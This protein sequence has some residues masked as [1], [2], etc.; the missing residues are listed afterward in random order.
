MIGLGHLRMYARFALGLRGFLAEPTT[1]EVARSLLAAR[2]ANRDESFL[3]VA[4]RGIYGHAGSPYLPLL[5]R[6]GCELGDLQRMV[7]ADG[8]EP[9]LATLRCSGVYFSFEEWKGRRPVVRGDLELGVDAHSFDN[10]HL[11]KVYEGST[12]GSTGVGTR[13]A[14]DLDDIAARAPITLLAQKAQGVLDLPRATVFGRLPDPTAINSILGM[15]RSGRRIDRWFCPVIDGVRPTPIQYRV[16]HHYVVRVGRWLGVAV[17]DPEPLPLNETVRVARWAAQACREHGG[18]AISSSASMA[19]RIATAAREADI[20][21]TGVVMMSGGEPLTQAKAEAIAASGARAIPSYHMS[22]VGA[23]G[24]GC[25]RAT[26]PNDQ[27]FQ[28]DH[29]ALIQAPRSVGSFEVQAFL[30]TTLLPTAKRI[31]LNVEI[32]DYGTVEPS[33]CGCPLETYGFDRVLRHIRSFSKLTAEG[34]T[35]VGSEMEHILESVLPARFGGTPL[36]YQLME[37][38][39]SAGLTRVVLIIAPRVG[40]VDEGAVIEAVL[41]ALRGASLGTAVGGGLL[42]AAGSLR[43][44]RAEPIV[45]ARGKLLPLHLGQRTPQALSRV[46][47]EVRAS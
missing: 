4:E 41:T 2:L 46:E 40:F 13:L 45:T 37:E 5:R 10:P 33:S 36:D 30:L 1:I 22:E 31:L 21:L 18:A 29:L 24:R 3:K 23:I 27:H 47:G 32:D 20:D 42:S 17:P 16:T 39:D 8:L 34:V 26:D 25:P 44:R 12:G 11:S 43:V 14:L 28:S 38:E 9:T 7:R 35:L 6:A 19:V 15:A